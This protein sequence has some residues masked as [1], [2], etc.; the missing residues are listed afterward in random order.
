MKKEEFS[1]IRLHLNKTQSQMA[2]LL[3]VSLKAIQSFEQ[4][5]RSIPTHIER[6]TLLLLVM[7]NGSNN[8]K[9]CWVLTKCPKEKKEECPA[10]ELMC[11][12]LCWFV[13]GT[14]CHGEV[15]SDWEQKMK[16]CRK[17]KVFKTMTHID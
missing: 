3:G 17:C 15:Q 11:G 2:Q 9:A 6:Q 4:G 12:D 16:L 14:I 1:D 8:R 5:W 10:W 13:N 7:K